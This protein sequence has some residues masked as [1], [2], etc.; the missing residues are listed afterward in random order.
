MNDQT[1]KPEGRTNLA[2]ARTVLAVERT[3]NT[4]I[5][6]AIGFL[7]G[8]LA[9]TKLMEHEL[10]SLHGAIIL[11]G[12]TLLAAVAITITVS[13]TLRYRSRMNELGRQALGRW[14]FRVIVFISS[15]FVVIC[16]IGLICLY[17]L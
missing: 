12:S 11:A 5:R 2:Y 10:D 4:W 9:L 13:A 15:S 17:M 1:P 6:T 3:Y 7:A 14:P 8:G 16:L